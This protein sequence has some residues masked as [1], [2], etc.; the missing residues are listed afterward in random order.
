MNGVGGFFLF[1]GRGF[2]VRASM[3]TMEKTEPFPS[4]KEGKRLWM[5]KSR[6]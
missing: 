6:L 2:F 5:I 1:I 4:E 3:E